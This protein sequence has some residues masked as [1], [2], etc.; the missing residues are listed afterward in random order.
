MR[1]VVGSD[2]KVL[3]PFPPDSHLTI[4]HSDYWDSDKWDAKDYGRDYDF[5]RP[6]FEQFREL[7]HEVPWSHAYNVEGTNSEYCSDVISLT[8]CYLIFN[9]GYSENCYYGNEFLHSRNSID[10]T[11]LRDSQLCYECLD[12]ERCYQCVSCQD[13]FGCT[14]VSYSYN[15]RD[16]HDCVGCVNLKHKS[17]CIFNEQ[18]S[19]E[20][21]E[22][23][24]AE[25][26]LGSRK[27]IRN[28]QDEVMRL[29]LALPQKYIHGV[30]NEDVTGDYLNH[31]KNA[32]QSFVCNDL[33]DCKYNQYIL[34]VKSKDCYDI[35]IAGGELCY[36]L[37]EAGGYNVKLSLLAVS[38][39]VTNGRLTFSDIEYVAN[40][41]NGHD[42]FACVGLKNASYCI[43]NKQYTKE[44]Y[45]ALKDKII[46]HMKDMPY[47]DS[48]G[49][50]YSY[51][52][53][54]PPEFAL[55]PYEETIAQEYF[56]LPPGEIKKFGFVP[57]T[58]TDNTFTATLEKI[59]DSIVEVKDE[60]TKE[61]LPC[62]D[63]GMCQH[64][65]TKAFKVIPQELAFYR[66]MGL[67][68]PSRCHNCRHHERM[69]KR[70]PLQ[71]HHRQCMCE[72]DHK[73]AG[74]GCCTNEFETTFAPDRS[75]KVFCETCFQ[76]AT[77]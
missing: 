52:E 45:F 25:L 37:E 43:F 56:P 16:C 59:P 74:T 29:R 63:N 31:C 58:H 1:D 19:K 3:S 2:K 72:L 50:V 8:N 4:Y 40:C 9:S 68:L 38:K 70:N 42:L 66:E 73:H 13:C 77:E 26:Q 35:T 64:G 54:F 20:E 18:Y 39:D 24:V 55:T 51:G 6:F 10:C 49:R 44:E 33:E 28:V 14:N 76:Q 12:C 41:I 62:D 48:L 32:E 27:G 47:R 22:K 61:L 67:P 5:S 75:E 11:N 46:Q 23:K 57:K 30:G 21:Y 71:L 65:C 15:L 69:G 60:V 36:E 17:Y 53:F 34:F 7:M